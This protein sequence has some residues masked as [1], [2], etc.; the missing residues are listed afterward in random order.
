MG[1][2][3]AAALALLGLRRGWAADASARAARSWPRA[4]VREGQWR[5]PVLD[6]GFNTK[7]Y[8]TPNPTREDASLLLYIGFTNKPYHTCGM[9]LW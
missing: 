4:E 5:S 8:H 2:S 7:P 9:A 3:V 1:A 6:I